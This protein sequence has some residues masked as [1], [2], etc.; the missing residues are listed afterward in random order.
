MSAFLLIGTIVSGIGAA[1]LVLLAF[2]LGGRRA[3]RWLL[4]VVAGA[5]M[6]A[7]HVSLENSWFRR[8][9]AQLSDRTMVI[10][11][12]A[13]Q[14][15]WQPWTLIWPQTVR[16]TAIDRDRLAPLADDLVQ[17]EVW[18]VDR[19]HGSSRIVQVYDCAAPRRADRFEAAAEP[20]PREPA[21]GE[22]VRIAPDD[23]LRRAACAMRDG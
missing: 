23:P 7:M 21:E 18:L 15:W 1:G 2:R 8:L 20:E 19:F 10:E 17:V 14:A 13:R 3:P 4:P 16:F 9:E 22:W 12:F 6:L 11:T 5:V